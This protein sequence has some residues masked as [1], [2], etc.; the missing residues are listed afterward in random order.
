MNCKFFIIF[1]LFLIIFITFCHAD[2]N[3]NN[4]EIEPAVLILQIGK[5]GE[6]KCD[7]NDVFELKDLIWITPNNVSLKD[8]QSDKSKR[9]SNTKGVLKIKKI[10]IHDTGLYKCTD[11]SK[12][13]VTTSYLKV[14]EMPSYVFEG[15]III[16]VDAILF[17]LFVASIIH[18]Y[19]IN[20]IKEDVQ[21]F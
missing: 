12:S 1:Y 16:A 17:F 21:A 8:G 7:A 20:R 15:S 4:L 19:R 10:S 3:E 2:E 13:N 9:L 11:A 18:K 6:F 14:F 5:E